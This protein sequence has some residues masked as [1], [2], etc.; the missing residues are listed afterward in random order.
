ML[1]PGADQSNVQM[2]DVLC[3]FCHRAWTADVPFIEG[4]RGAVMCGQ[5]LTVA[6]DELVISRAG[7]TGDFQCVLCREGEKDRAAENRPDEPGW[8]SALD[9]SVAVCRRCVKRAAGVLH[10]DPDYAWRKP[11]RSGGDSSRASDS[12]DS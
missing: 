10:K 3:D 5:C 11:E 6:Y 4:H 7:E 12:D 2:E 9:E 1:R 8:K